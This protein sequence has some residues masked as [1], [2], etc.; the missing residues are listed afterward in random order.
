MQKNK[1]M[2]GE[3][4]AGKYLIGPLIGKGSFGEVYLSTV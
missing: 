3:T 1:S 4:I 2:T